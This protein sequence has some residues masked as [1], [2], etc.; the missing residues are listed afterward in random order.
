MLVDKK[1]AG[2][3]GFIIGGGPSI[4]Q[5]MQDGF[6]FSSLKNEVTIAVNRSY[7]LLRSTYLYYQDNYIWETFGAEI[8]RLP[9]K[10]KI[11]C[12]FSAYGAGNDRVTPFD[13][14]QQ[15]NLHGTFNKPMGTKN[16][17]GVTAL[18][19]AYTLGLNPIYLIGIDLNREDALPSKFNFHTDYDPKRQAK[20]SPEKIDL[21]K[22]YFIQTIEELERVGVQTFSCSKTSSLNAFIPYVDI[23][24]IL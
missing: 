9:K 11:I 15:A 1:H 19:I 4:N 21:F 8:L 23:K 6:R 20:I 22:K 18:R 17:A 7:K 14:I 3:R 10:T 12:P 24:N 5:I 2:E 13:T 16:N